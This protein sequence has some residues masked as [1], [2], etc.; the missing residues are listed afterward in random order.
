MVGVGTYNMAGASDWRI[1][2][3]KAPVVVIDISVP[4]MSDVLYYLQKMDRGRVVL[5]PFIFGRIVSSL[6]H[7]AITWPT[8]L[9]TKTIGVLCQ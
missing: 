8:K 6:L 7:M 2:G 3:P 4:L 1:I 5:R 9:Q